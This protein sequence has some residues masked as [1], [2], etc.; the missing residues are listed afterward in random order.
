MLCCALH[1]LV[2]H[3]QSYCGSMSRQQRRDL[4]LFLLGDLLDTVFATVY[5]S[6]ASTAHIAATIA[7]QQQAR[8]S[9][10]QEK[11]GWNQPRA[12]GR[13]KG[14]DDWESAMHRMLTAEIE[15]MRLAEYFDFSPAAAPTATTTTA[16][17]AAAAADAATQ[18]SGLCRL[19]FACAALRATAAARFAPL[20]DPLNWAAPVQVG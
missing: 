12:G 11:Q 8:Q 14:E 16:A 7:R 3:D 17:A 15:D 10:G 19:S 5:A 13:I 4:S 2:I 9:Q 1:Q 6:A 18:W 20:S